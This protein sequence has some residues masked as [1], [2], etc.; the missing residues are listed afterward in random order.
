MSVDLFVR[1]SF[2]FPSS[3]TF[4][5]VRQE[6]EGTHRPFSLSSTHT[7]AQC[8]WKKHTSTIPYTGRHKCNLLS[9]SLSLSLNTE[10]H[11]YFLPLFL[12]LLLGLFSLSLYIFSRGSVARGANEGHVEVR[13]KDRGA[14]S[15]TETV[16]EKK[17][18]RRRKEKSHPKKVKWKERP[19]YTSKSQGES[20]NCILRPGYSKRRRTSFYRRQLFC[21]FAY[22]LFK[23]FFLLSFFCMPPSVVQ[24]EPE[25]HWQVHLLIHLTKQMQV[26]VHT[27]NYL[28][29]CVF[30][31]GRGGGGRR[32][33]RGREEY[34]L[35]RS[36]MDV[37]PLGPIARRETSSWEWRERRGEREKKSRKNLS[38][39]L[40]KVTV[41]AACSTFFLSSF[42]LSSCLLL[43]FTLCFSFLFLFLSLSFAPLLHC[44]RL[45]FVIT[46]ETGGVKWLNDFTNGCSIDECFKALES[47][48]TRE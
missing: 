29:V 37:W 42:P 39:P 40:V 23:W 38:D 35:H 32:R 33:R 36:F 21:S 10:S 34:A 45:G 7:A 12:S 24:S 16:R 48:A 15:L 46:Y 28:Y 19:R 1:F 2:F 17:K 5:A 27:L 41:G 30:S 18:R 8:K 11:F 3:V 20:H 9:L 14:K 22:I 4:T 44:K 25:Q 31:C 47:H 13:R 6:T 26:R 43:S